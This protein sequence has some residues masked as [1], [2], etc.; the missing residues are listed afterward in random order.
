MNSQK[1]ILIVDD[2][3]LLVETIAFN[4]ENKG[5]AVLKAFDGES[6]LAQA[7]ELKPHLMILDVMLPHLSGWDVCRT[8]RAASTYGKSLPILMLTARGEARDKEKS[9]AAGA[10]D[11]LLKPFS[12]QE[13]IQRI[14]T[15]LTN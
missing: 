1:T 3:P 6:G 9:M 10:T 15:L 12:M 2:E 8:L 14:Q 7:L 5:F 13:L 4:L 11:Y